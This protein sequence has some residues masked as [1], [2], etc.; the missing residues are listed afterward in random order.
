[1]I[2]RNNR[3]QPI[4]SVLI[5]ENTG[6]KKLQRSDITKEKVGE[7]AFGLACLPPKWTLPF[8]VISSELYRTYSIEKSPFT[9]GTEWGPMVSRACE[10]IFGESNTQIVI[11]SSGKRGQ[12]YF[13]NITGRTP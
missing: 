9:E 3:L 11:R 2:S 1:M 4:H 6:L 5:V 7:K 10:E 13:F 8:F 12:I